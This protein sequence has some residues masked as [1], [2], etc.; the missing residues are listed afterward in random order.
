MN[1]ATRRIV[2]T[3]GVLLGIAGMEHG[4]FEVL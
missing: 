2:S 4:F 1:R 3:I